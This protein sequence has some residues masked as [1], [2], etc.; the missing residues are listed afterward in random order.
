MVAVAVA[1]V[2]LVLSMLILQGQTHGRIDAARTELAGKVDATNARID[3]T[4]G[5]LADSIEATNDRIDA[6]NA[7]IDDVLEALAG[8]GDVASDIKAIRAELAGP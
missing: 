1:L 2:A 3:A 8:L 7:R 6:T 5:E 4:R